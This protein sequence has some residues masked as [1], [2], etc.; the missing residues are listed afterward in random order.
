[1][2]APKGKDTID[3]GRGN[4]TV[5]AND[6]GWDKSIDC[7]PGDDV[8]YIDPA[9]TVGGRSVS[10]RSR[11]APL[12]ICCA[13]ALSGYAAALMP[14]KRGCALATPSAAST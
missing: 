12:S 3:A 5:F 4:D 2:Y 8:L 6:G 1:M 10:A 11:G 7:G 9:S 14:Y 13:T